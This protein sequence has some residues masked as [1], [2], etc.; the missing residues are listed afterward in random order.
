MDSHCLLIAAIDHI[1]IS[2]AHQVF[3]SAVDL[4]ICSINMI[5]L[6]ADESNGSVGEYEVGT[7]LVPTA[8][9]LSKDRERLS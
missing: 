5:D 6:L 8:K 2:N 9:R 1:P 4:L 7:T 3:E